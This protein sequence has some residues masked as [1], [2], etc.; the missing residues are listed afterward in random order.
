MWRLWRKLAWFSMTQG[1]IVWMLCIDNKS[2]RTKNLSKL[3]CF[4]DTRPDSNWRPTFTFYNH[5]QQCSIWN[6]L[7][8]IVDERQGKARQGRAQHILQRPKYQIHLP[9][10]QIVWK[11]FRNPKYTSWDTSILRLYAFKIPDKINDLV[12]WWY[13]AFYIIIII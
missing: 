7:D 4:I 3:N 12:N 1:H 2:T 8:E 11:K 9:F 13:G 5:P 6:V 10:L